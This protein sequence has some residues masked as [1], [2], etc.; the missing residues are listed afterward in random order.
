MESKCKHC[1]WAV[2]INHLYYCWK[3]ETMDFMVDAQYSTNKKCVVGYNL[4]ALPTMVGC[5]YHE[6]GNPSDK[7]NLVDFHKEVLAAFREE[8]NPNGEPKDEALVTLYKPYKK[9]IKAA[10]HALEEVD[11]DSRQY[12]PEVFKAWEIGLFVIY[13]R[14]L[15]S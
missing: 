5:Q 8:F 1:R 9:E 14:Q 11:S 10:Y 13:L 4:N 6:E 2:L 3:S 12:K 7:V 15:S